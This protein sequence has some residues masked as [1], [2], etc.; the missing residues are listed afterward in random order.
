MS[1]AALKLFTL[2]LRKVV[3]TQLR[4]EAVPTA[5]P[6]ILELFLVT[7]V[8]ASID[9]GWLGRPQT[10]KLHDTYSV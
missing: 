7:T 5:A 10:S 6:L 1:A 3:I 4:L 9:Q 2:G 8:M